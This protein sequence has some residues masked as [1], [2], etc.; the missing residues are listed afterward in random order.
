MR[1]FQADDGQRWTARIHDGSP[2]REHILERV[3]WEAILFEAVPFTGDQRLVYRPTGWLETAPATELIAALDEAEAIRASWGVTSQP[4]A[5][6][7]RRPP[8]AAHG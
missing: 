1:E 8:D 4:A 3:G 5:P 2:G 7:P 6:D